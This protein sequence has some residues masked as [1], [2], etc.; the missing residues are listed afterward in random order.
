MG[1]ALAYYRPLLAPLLILLI[2]IGGLVFGKEAAQGQLFSELNN[3]VGPE[4]A[5]AIQAMI[6]GA[7]KPASGIVAS[8]ISFA[9][10]VFGASS[11]AGELKSSVNA[12]WNRPVDTGGIKEI[13]KQRS[14]AL[15]VVLGCGFLLLVSLTVSSAI[16]AAGKFVAGMLPMPEVIMQVLGLVLSFAVITGVFAVLLKYCPMLT[17]SGATYSRERHSPLSCLQWASSSSACTWARR[18]SDPPTAPPA[19]SLLSWC[20]STT[21]LRSSSSEPRSPRCIRMTMAPGV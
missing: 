19:L 10:L 20:G 21:P 17:W 8:L 12:I 1:A 15:G 2:A 5:K 4:G 7:S 9:T 13:I 3:M 18:V 11:V 6:E 14:A 16:A